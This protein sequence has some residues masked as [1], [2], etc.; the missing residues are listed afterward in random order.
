[1][2]SCATQTDVPGFAGVTDASTSVE[3]F[4][5]RLQPSKQGTNPPAVPGREAALG[6][7]MSGGEVGKFTERSEG[8]F[9]VPGDSH[10]DCFVEINDFMV[11]ARVLHGCELPDDEFFVLREFIG[12]VRVD[13][14]TARLA[15]AKAIDHSP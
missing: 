9:V 6:N 3:V 15:T 12:P 7:E 14:T 10:A 1:V 11:V 13:V 4:A 2:S 5:D 8:Q